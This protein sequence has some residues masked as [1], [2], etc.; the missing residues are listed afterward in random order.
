MNKKLAHKNRSDGFIAIIAAV[1]LGA[2]VMAVALSG[3]AT[4]GAIFDQVNRKTYRLIA[5]KNAL[6]CLD[7]V[8]LELAH[9]YFY[10]VGAAAVQYPSKQCSIISVTPM[11]S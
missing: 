1:L 3:S 6:Y 10:T 8:F 4:I 5:T 11:A 9:D 7:Q 2:A